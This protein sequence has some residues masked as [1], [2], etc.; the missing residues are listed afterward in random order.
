[1]KC[2]DKERWL[3]YLKGEMEDN[4]RVEITDHIE[5][6]ERCREMAQKL[7]ETLKILDSLDALDAEPQ[8]ATMV[9]GKIGKRHQVRPWERIVLPAIAATAAILSI[10]IGIFLGQSLYT[11]SQTDNSAITSTE[12]AF[13]SYGAGPMNLNGN[14]GI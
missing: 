6:C 5:I 4:E 13:Q 14:G 10:V 12:T 11:S 8:F 1:M 9:A 2:I 3:K 7:S